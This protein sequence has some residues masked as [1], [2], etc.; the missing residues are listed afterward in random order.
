M[1]SAVTAEAIIR[2]GSGSHSAAWLEQKLRDRVDIVLR[3]INR[4]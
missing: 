1:L 3:G 2:W 4:E